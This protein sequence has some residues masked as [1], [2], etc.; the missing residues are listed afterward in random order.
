[1]AGQLAFSVCTE[2]KCLMEK[3][4]LALEITVD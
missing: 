4:D 2:D 3:R 1:V